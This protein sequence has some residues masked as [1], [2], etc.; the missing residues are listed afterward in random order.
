MKL[1]E[2]RIIKHLQVLD[3]HWNP[4]YWL[5]SGDGVLYLMR[6]RADGKQAMT[7]FGGVDPDYIVGSFSNIINDG[8]G[9]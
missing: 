8:G 2:A 5:W 7:D 9:W 1:S 3:N 4:N 6:F